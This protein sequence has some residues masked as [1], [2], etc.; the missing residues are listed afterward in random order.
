M[1]TVFASNQHMHPEANSTE[2][3]KTAKSIQ[4]PGPCEIEIINRSY[5]FVQVYGEF[6][7]GAWLRFNIPPRDAAH[8]ISLFYYGYCHTDMYLNITTLDGY[9]V[10]TGYPRPKTTIEVVP[11]FKN[12][13]KAEVKSK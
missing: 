10:Y 6:D 2:I 4:W 8:Y 3:K 5:E 7:D 9:P 13:L 12:T 11:Y 1:A